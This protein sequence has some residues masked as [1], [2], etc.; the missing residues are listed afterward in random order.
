M[1]INLYPYI[2]VEPGPL[3]TD[4][5][6][7]KVDYP[8]QSAM[9]V[10]LKDYPVNHEVLGTSWRMGEVH[11][12]TA[13]MITDF[14]AYNND[15]NKLLFHMTGEIPAF[16]SDVDGYY[17]EDLGYDF[18]IG[19]ADWE[20]NEPMKVKL[21][22]RINQAGST[23]KYETSYI[24]VIDT[25][26]APPELTWWQKLLGI[27]LAPQ[28]KQM[29]IQDSIFAAG[30]KL[31]TGKDVTLAEVEQ[32]KLEIMDWILPIDILLK[33]FTGKNLKGE[34]EEFG[35]GGDWLE[36]MFMAVLLAI[37][38]PLDDVGARAAGKAISKTGAAELTAK[39]GEKA[40]V[41]KLIKVVKKNPTSS[42][43]L[44]SKFPVAVRDA[45]I[46]GLGK[47]SFGREAIYALGETGFFRF[48][49][50]VWSK[51]LTTL[52]KV[53]SIAIAATLPIFAFTEIPNWLNMR[54]F[55]RKQILQEEGNWPSDIAFKLNSLED[56]MRDYAYNVDKDI[57]AGRG[58]DAA[59]KIETLKGTL[60]EFKAYIEEKKDVMLPEDYTWG[61]ELIEFYNI[62]ISDR[63]K[64]IAEIE[65]PPEAPPVK[66]GYGY[67]KITSY[68]VGAKITIAGHP[69]I[70][71]EGTYLLLE[72]SYTIYF[73]LEGYKPATKYVTII[74]I[75]TKEISAVLIK[76]EEPEPSKAEL[77][78]TS[79]PSFAGVTIDGKSTYQKT[80]YT[81]FLDEGLHTI[82]VELADYE[83]QEENIDLV[84]GDEKTKE[85][86]LNKTPPT[87]GVLRILSDP[88]G[89]QVYINGESK[90]ATTPYTITLESATYKVRL[91]KDGYLPDETDV[92]V[93][94]GV[95]KEHN[96]NLILKPITKATITITSEPTESDIY[97]DGKY[98]YVKTPY[99]IMLDPKDY[100]LRV[101][102]DGYYPIEI[103]AE[104][105]EGEVSEIP[106]IL[107][108]IPVP[109]VPAEPYI[110]Y[111]P[112]YPDY[113]PAEPYVP[114]VVTT[115]SYEIPAYNYSNLWPEIT[116]IPE[117]AAVSPPT[118]KELMINIETT[119]LLP[120]NGRIY[121]IAILDLSD[122]L[123]EVQI[124]VLDD[125]ETLIRG[126]L[127][128]FET[129]GYAKLVGY[130]VAFDYRY[131]FAKMMKYRIVSKAWKN[132]EL[133]DVMQIMQQVKEAFV[134]GY[135]KPGTLDEWGKAL[136]GKGKYGAQDL[137]L[138]KYISGDFDYC[139]AFQ[140]RQIE[141][142]KG[143]YDLARFCSS[144]AFIS[145]P[146][147]IPE[148]SSPAPEAETSETPGIQ[149]NK[150][151]PVCKAYNP[152]SA[153][154]CEI[155]GA[156]I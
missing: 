34:P 120:F 6:E 113:T 92:I 74:A 142:T 56:L 126:F 2:F 23:L 39:L 54:Q 115:P 78:I 135:N 81:A 128:M 32:K 103:I 108:L 71:E 96:I 27:V 47:T 19:H 22:T 89:A 66:P 117:V 24:D 77:L 134:F 150:I 33:L 28:L 104:V 57:Q 138:K 88:S 87:K 73:E 147:P 15:T 99:T 8:K 51:A 80:P 137:M 143:L 31:L 118:E 152:L 45:V 20:I 61:K 40:T 102:K 48:I 139:K 116:T 106:F 98:Q 129:A 55:A 12:L 101:Q 17:Y 86:I 141:L 42:A 119:D 62:F 38:G 75:E 130:N 21:V 110:P 107:E 136:L 146:A 10:D 124:A 36:L 25:S 64:R 67:L 121:S 84:W 149:G 16:N 72:G 69:E 59:A 4:S 9:Q 11:S 94:A 44:L 63:E 155:C 105:E 133:R 123:A 50:P 41:T 145:S 68:P 37:P 151:C 49:R 18:W 85:F 30:Y 53:S 90:F 154:I 109:E 132:I 140:N 100:I 35:S 65:I 82:R 83:P 127:D 144:E 97:I 91:T 125:E 93:E 131:I 29:L 153:K 95:E 114:S 46:A 26:I 1:A 5:D 70:I 122:P 14:W 3:F 13:P 156:S 148:T 60:E 112:Y 111:E 76:E 7:A 43:K 79:K 52:F 58:I